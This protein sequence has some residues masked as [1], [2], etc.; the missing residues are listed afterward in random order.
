MVDCIHNRP[1]SV[2]GHD[3]ACDDFVQKKIQQKRI[4]STPQHKTMRSALSSLRNG[5]NPEIQHWRDLADAIEIL[6]I[7]GKDTDSRDL[8]RD[9]SDAVVPAGL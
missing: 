8:D 2:C 7:L 3:P 5:L 9:V 6:V 4:V 1:M